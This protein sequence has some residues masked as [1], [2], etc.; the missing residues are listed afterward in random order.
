MKRKKN[1]SIEPYLS[2]RRDDE[3]K[4]IFEI[5]GIDPKDW[6]PPYRMTHKTL[7]EKYQRLSQIMEEQNFILEFSEKL[8]LLE[9][10]RH[11]TEVFLYEKDYAMN[12]GWVC[13]VTGC[14]GDCPSC[15]Q[16]EY[17]DFIN[18]VWTHEKMEAELRRR[19]EHAAGLKH[20]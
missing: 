10:Y 19:C 5:L 7:K 12:K 8:P 1:D 4:F 2:P 16:R 6:L 20:L 9:A 17:C 14:G 13:H 18:E 15:F 3:E 11:L